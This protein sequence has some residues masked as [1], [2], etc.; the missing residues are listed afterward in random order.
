MH[1]FNSTNNDCQSSAN[2]QLQE[3]QKSRP[4]DVN[5]EV[6]DPFYN[7]QQENECGPCSVESGVDGISKLLVGGEGHKPGHANSRCG[8]T[9][10]CFA[11]RN[12]VGFGRGNV[13]L[14]RT[15]GN[16]ESKCDEKKRQDRV[17][18]PG[19]GNVVA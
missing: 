12:Q 19:L 9:F 10:C 2:H 13:F 1:L 8:S 14:S 3:T 7:C 5:N 4:V 16:L 6:D 18:K 15:E 11:A 17:G